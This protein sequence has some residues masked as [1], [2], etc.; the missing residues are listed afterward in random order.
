[1]CFG[2]D[3]WNLNVSHGSLYTEHTSRA[4]YR[5]VILYTLYLYEYVL[6]TNTGFNTMADSAFQLLMLCERRYEAFDACCSD[7]YVI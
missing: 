7:Q 3:N 2:L 4:Y 1:M 6:D 5:I